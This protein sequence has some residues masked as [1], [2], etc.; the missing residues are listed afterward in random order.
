MSMSSFEEFF[1]EYA[2]GDKK[3][4]HTFSITGKGF[5]KHASKPGQYQ[6]PNLIPDKHKPENDP[7]KKTVKDVRKGTIT[8][9]ILKDEI[10]KL[11]LTPPT[12]VGK[13]YGVHVGRS[14]NNTNHAVIYLT[15]NNQY[16]ITQD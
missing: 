5:Q 7:T 14:G 15:P 9:T 6:N 1:F 16:I 8:R 11:G 4:G 2:K 3:Q 10:L 12:K 13:E